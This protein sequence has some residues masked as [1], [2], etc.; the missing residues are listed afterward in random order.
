M[1]FQV[2]SLLVSF[3]PTSGKLHGGGIHDKLI[4]TNFTIPPKQDSKKAR[5]CWGG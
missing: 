3:L 5:D 2:I 4:V 1:A